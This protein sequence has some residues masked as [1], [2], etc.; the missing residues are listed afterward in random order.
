[1]LLFSDHCI[2]WRK[3]PSK[4]ISAY[5]CCSFQE[6]ITKALIIYDTV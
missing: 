4:I 2:A 3:N 5:D 6:I 1:M